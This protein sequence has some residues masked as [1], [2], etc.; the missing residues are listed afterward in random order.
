MKLS[1][2]V[3]L[4]LPLTVLKGPLCAEA[5]GKPP[6]LEGVRQS[7]VGSN[8]ASIRSP[9]L[10]Q[11]RVVCYEDEASDED[12]DPPL[13]DCDGAPYRRP[14]EAPRRLAQDD[15]GIVVANSSLE[16]DE[17]SQ[18]GGD[19]RRNP[20]SEA[21]T[22]FYNSSAE[23]EDGPPLEPLPL[24]Q[25]A[26]S[27]FVPIRGFE[28]DGGGV[29]GGLAVRKEG[30]RDGQVESKRSPKLEH[31]AVTRVKSMMSIECPN[32]N[33]TPRPKSEE[34]PPAPPPLLPLTRPRPLSYCKRAE[35][36]ELAGVCTIETVVLTRAQDESFGL[37]LEIQSSP[38]KVL[39]TGL[40]PGG[41]ADRVRPFFCLKNTN[42]AKRT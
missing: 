25:G 20:S 8:P 4:C 33:V 18:D 24:S 42:P 34:T 21:P 40:R 32:H 7:S 36:S 26:E 11:R 28:H 2:V 35:P 39:I 16:V 22:P 1:A 37:D 14:P 31:K 12:A 30:H 41:A 23:S 29:S 19:L 17:D 3:M 15:S 27:P 9:L 13:P 10:R 6:G 38:L 5:G